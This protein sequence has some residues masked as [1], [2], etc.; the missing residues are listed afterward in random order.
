[1]KKKI[2]LSIIIV[3]FNTPTLVKDAV[4]SCLLASDGL[5]IEIIIVNNGSAE[6]KAV[7]SFDQTKVITIEQSENK[8]FGSAVNVGFANSHGKYCLLLN[9]DAKIITGALHKMVNFLD[10]Y[11]KAGVVGGRIRNKDNLTEVSYGFFPNLFVEFKLK[12]YKIMLENIDSIR[13]SFEKKMSKAKKV[14]WLSGAFIMLKRNLFDKIDCFDES[15]FL[16]FED[17]DFCKR[18]SIEG[19]YAFYLPSAECIH[20]KSSSVKKLPPKEILKIKRKSQGIYYSKYNSFL[21]N[22]LLKCVTFKR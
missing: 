6:K 11:D 20:E 12:I 9:S 21:S 15:Y 5:E 10:I 2:D 16:Y 13:K 22:L 8:G 4:E 3:N 1:M 17:I 7:G 19:Y 18:L 14:D